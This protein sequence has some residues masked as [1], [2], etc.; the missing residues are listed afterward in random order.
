MYFTFILVVYLIIEI[1]LREGEQFGLREND[2]I[3]AQ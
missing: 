3:R 2:A 1:R